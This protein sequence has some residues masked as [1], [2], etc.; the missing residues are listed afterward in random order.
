MDLW[1]IP[2]EQHTISQHKGFKIWQQMFFC[3]YKSD[4]WS[5]VLYLSDC[6][7]IEYLTMVSST[8]NEPWSQMF[9]IPVSTAENLETIVCVQV[10]CTSVYHLGL[11]RFSKTK[12]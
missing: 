8:G 6:I 5:L 3:F 11:T 7:W 10:N 12:P 4:S 2:P 9:H 1:D